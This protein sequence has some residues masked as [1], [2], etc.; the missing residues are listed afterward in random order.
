MGKKKTDEPEKD[1]SEDK[2][3][4]T[5][6]DEE[7]E[8][9]EDTPIVKTLKEIDVR[10]CKLEAEYE[11]EVDALRKKYDALPAPILDERSKALADDSTAEDKSIATPA[12][13]GFWLQTLKN[14]EVNQCIEDYDEPILQYLKDI[15]S[16]D[17]KEIP[18]S[19]FRLEFFFVE[20]P[21][22]T[23]ESLWVELVSDYD[24][25]KY[26]PYEDIEW[27]EVKSSGV[28]WKAGK[29]VTVTL[30]TKK[31]KGGGGKKAKQKAKTKEEPQP[32]FFRMLFRSLKKGDAAPADVVLFAGQDEEDVDDEEIVDDFLE[33]MGGLGEMFKELV[34][35]YAIRLYTGEIADDDD[36]DDEDEEE[37]SEDIDEE[38][39]DDDEDDDVPLVPSKA[40]SKNKKKESPKLGPTAPKG[41]GKGKGQEECKQ[42]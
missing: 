6:S 9:E 21:Y 3:K 16:T 42:Q 8:E 18:R 36:D 33:Q 20:N 7:D 13:P 25:E 5:K 10:Y 4:N 31:V 17:L 27:L 35:P 37:E 14:S 39:D 1:T 32:S 34:I 26:K 30:T 40:K 11:A 2:E 22:F 29:N 28:D 24:P 23:N 12:C 19:G 41:D 15:G 38:I